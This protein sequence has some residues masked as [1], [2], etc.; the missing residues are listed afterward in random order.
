MKKFIIA[1]YVLVIIQMNYIL[2]IAS[3]VTKNVNSIL[4]MI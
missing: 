3:I 1:K 2:E 4:I